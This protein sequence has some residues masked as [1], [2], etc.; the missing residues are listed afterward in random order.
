VTKNGKP[1]TDITSTTNITYLCS[2]TKSQGICTYRLERI[3][4][5]S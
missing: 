2:C 3:L 5:L 4:V 1:F